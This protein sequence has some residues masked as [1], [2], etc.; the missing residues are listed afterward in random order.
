MTFFRYGFIILLA[1]VPFAASV[2]PQDL[3]SLYILTLIFLGIGFSNSKVVFLFLL[4]VIVVSTRTIV[5]DGFVGHMGAVAC[6]LF[7]FSMVVFISANL[8]RHYRKIKESKKELT[9]ALAKAL[10]SRDSF[11]ANHSE[12]VANV[13][14]KLAKE[15]NLSALQCE[16]VYT[17]SLLHDIGK[18]GVPEHILI[19]P[20]GLTAEEYERIKSHPEIGYETLKHIADFKTTGILDIVLHHHERFDGKGYPKGLKGGGISLFARIVAVA[21]SFD[22]MASKRLYR[23]EMA[24]SKI[25]DEID[26]HKGTQYDPQIAGIFLNLLKNGEIQVPSHPA[27]AKKHSI[28]GTVDKRHFTSW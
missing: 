5:D 20:T 1:L 28:E 16:A 11:T 21:D 7:T 23:D 12:N 14:L 4:C 10:D 22:A 9:I 26:R 3:S 15:M 17:G 24:L 13:A 2:F 8:A 6:R 27:D 25:V 19:K 18:I